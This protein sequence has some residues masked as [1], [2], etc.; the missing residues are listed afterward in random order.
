MRSAVALAVL[1]FIVSP[2]TLA[3][4]HRDIEEQ[5]RETVL[6]NYELTATTLSDLP[7]ETSEKGSLAFWSSGGLLQE[8]SDQDTPVTYDSFHLVPKHIQVIS[9][10]EDAGV[11]QFYVEGSYT[12]TDGA[13]VAHYLTRATQVFVLEG[14]EWKVRAAHFSPVTG[15]AGTHVTAVK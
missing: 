5:I 7:E 3:G 6:R 11:A 4:Q 8:V 2:S 15:G 12:P 9:M 13:P 1:L 10:G 14:G